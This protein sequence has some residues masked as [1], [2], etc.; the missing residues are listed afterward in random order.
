MTEDEWGV[1][2]ARLEVAAGERP[3]AYAR[4]VALLGALGYL[5]ILAALALLAALVAFVIVLVAKEGHLLLLLKVIWPIGA[6]ALIIVRSLSVR[7]DPPAGIPL[8]SEDVPELFHVI[9]EVNE[10]VRGPRVD[11]VLVSGDFNAFVAQVPRRLGVFGSTNYLVLGLPYMQALGPDEFRSVVAHELGHLSRR[12][13]PFGTWIYRVQATWA[14]LLRALE[15][16][17]SWATAPFR[18]FF[19]WYAPYFA[20]YSFPLR[21]KHEYEADAAA[22]NVAGPQVAASALAVAAIGGTYLEREFWPGVYAGADREAEP[23]KAAFANLGAPVATARAHGRAADWLRAELTRPPMPHDTHPSLGQRIERLGLNTADVVAN[24]TGN[25]NA[26]TRETAAHAFLGATE[27]RLVARLDQA[28]REAVTPSWHERYKE[29][30]EARVRLEELDKRAQTESLSPDETAERAHLAASFKREEALPLLQ[31]LVE[32]SPDDAAAHFKLGQILLAQGDER[33]LTSLERAM[34]LDA[35][36]TISACELGF[37]FLAHKD[38]PRAEGYRRHANERA[39][40]LQAAQAERMTVVAAGPFAPH[41]LDGQTVEKLRTRL[42]GVGKLKRAYLVRKPMR[43]LDEEFPLHV[44]V[45][46][47][48]GLIHNRQRLVEDVDMRLQFAGWLLCPTDVKLK[49]LRLD[50]IPGAKIYEL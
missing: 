12:H 18:R 30:N 14:Q 29:A 21:R 3:R 13:G 33:G 31:E 20:A 43:H 44:L 48:R 24:V 8:G 19:E 39:G 16:A 34:E 32:R 17:E 26:A 45:L 49:R 22:A 41:T 27:S 46:Q 4:T 2:V 11:C 6:L 38:P 25:G 37:T 40:A 5:V 23:P 50:R 1:L 15:Q 35:D 9:G 28:W 42:A 36:A 10:Q 47:P 7:I